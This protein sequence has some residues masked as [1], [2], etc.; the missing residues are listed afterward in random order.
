M[1]ALSS[2]EIFL[3]IQT[4]YISRNDFP[5]QDTLD[6]LLPSFRPTVGWLWGKIPNVV[7]QGSCVWSHTQFLWLWEVTSLIN[8]TWVYRYTPL[9]DN[10]MEPSNE[11]MMGGKVK[12]SQCFMH[13][14][15]LCNQLGQS[16]QHRR[17]SN[18]SHHMLDLEWCH[19]FMTGKATG[20]LQSAL[21]THGLTAHTSL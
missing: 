14:W 17:L 16:A 21:T 19:S 11:L 8:V 13:M 6:F 7:G 4:N 3:A 2:E 18:S 12:G 1:I 10:P 20:L 9:T 15:C 5:P